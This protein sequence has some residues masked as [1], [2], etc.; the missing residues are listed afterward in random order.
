MT[1][2]CTPHHGRIL[3]ARTARRQR[4]RIAEQTYCAA[5]VTAAL[6]TVLMDMT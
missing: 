3:S 6:Q 4:D 2:L 1:I 5:A